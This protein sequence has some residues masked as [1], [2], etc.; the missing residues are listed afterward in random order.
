MTGEVLWQ[1]ITLD[2]NTMDLTED[3]EGGF[4]PPNINSPD[5]EGSVQFSV[6]LKKNLPNYEKIENRANI[7]FDLNA[8]ILTNLYSN[9]ID[10]DPPESQL[11]N[12]Y[13]TSNPKLFRIVGA[14]DDAQSKVSRVLVYAKINSCEY[15]PILTTSDK[16]FYIELDRDSTYY[17]FSQAKNVG[18]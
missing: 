18:K 8:P 9:R 3:P 5:G 14:S 6:Q 13:Y 15:F 2:T 7:Y 16:E 1:F 4:L 12:I 17:F 10:I 11:N